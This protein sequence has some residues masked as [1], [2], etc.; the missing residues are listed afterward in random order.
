MTNNIEGRTIAT[1]VMAVLF[2]GVAAIVLWD[3]TS[4]TD[5]DSYVFPRAISAVL[6]GLSVLSILRWMIFPSLEKVSFAGANLRRLGL[7][8]TMLGAT[9]AMPWVGFLISALFAYG[10]ILWL[11]MYDPWTPKRLVVYPLAGAGVVVGFYLLFSKTL[12]V[13]LPVGMIFGG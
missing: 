9:L 2:I 13:P 3:T 7:V 5:S 1:P 4:Y 11:A 6:I 12:Q 8:G 10:A